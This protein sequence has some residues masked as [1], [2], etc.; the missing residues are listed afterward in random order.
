MQIR[1]PKDREHMTTRAKRPRRSWGKI[2]RMRSGRYQ[3]GYNGPD[4]ARHYAPATF[5][6]RMDAEHWLA[7]ERRL[8]ERDE[9]TPP[10]HCAQAQTSSAARVVANTPPAGSSSAT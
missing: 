7:A 9:W 1:P 6:S 2:L 4:L 5:T 8:I 3:A 10:A